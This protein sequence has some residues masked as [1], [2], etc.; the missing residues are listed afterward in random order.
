MEGPVPTLNLK[1]N[2]ES[3]KEE[4]D[5]AM[6][7]VLASGQFVN[8]P[9]VRTFESQFAMFV[10]TKHC[11]GVSNG[12]DAL[13]LALEALEVGPGDEVILQ[14]NAGV[15]E[16]M[17]ID[18]VGAR[19]VLVDHDEASF[20]LDLNRVE[21]AVTDKTKAVLVVH[22]FGSCCDMTQLKAI[23]TTHHLKLIEHCTQAHG[24]SWE[25]R[26]LGSFG[27][28]GTWSFHPEDN[29]GAY[30]DAGGVTT[31]SDALED[32]LRLLQNDSGSKGLNHH[33]LDAIHAAVL[34][35]KLQY[36]LQW[37]RRRQELARMYYDL[38]CGVGDITF[39]TIVDGCIPAYSK[40]IVCTEKKDA[41]VHWLQEHHKIEVSTHHPVVSVQQQDQDPDSRGQEEQGS[42]CDHSLSLS[43]SH[44]SCS[45][46]LSLPV[47]PMMSDAMVMHVVTAVKSYY[48]RAESDYP[49][50]PLCPK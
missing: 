8:D 1:A 25:G 3:I 41:L 22:M 30:G 13:V 18:S 38:L 43:P 47:C 15:A 5:V 49:R 35:V 28:V 21:A 32:R 31:D 33:R 40:F 36:V 39:P 34:S 27:D 4:V 11:V 24:A 37:N 10:G 12:T 46:V 6:Q 20:Q 2:Y 9:A 7:K 17:A 14:G 44:S 19:A 48:L 42:P 29:L 26:F 16:A 45:T 23:C 50:P